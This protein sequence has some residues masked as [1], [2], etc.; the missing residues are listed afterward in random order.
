MHTQLYS[1]MQIIRGLWVQSF[2]QLHIYMWQK[3]AVVGPTTSWMQDNYSTTE[4][5]LQ[6]VWG[7]QVLL[8]YKSKSPASTT[9]LYSWY[10]MVFPICWISFSSKLDY[11]H[12]SLVS[13]V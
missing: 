4:P 5:Q 10:E 2:A 13:F 7:T 3:D 9:V 11:L 8:I 1:D 12:Y 6:I